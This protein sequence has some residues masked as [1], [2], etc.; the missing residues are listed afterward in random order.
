MGPLQYPLEYHVYDGQGNVVATT[1]LNGR[2][3]QRTGYDAFGERGWWLRLATA[4]T[5]G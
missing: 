4:T 3:H 2:V 1:D 5:I